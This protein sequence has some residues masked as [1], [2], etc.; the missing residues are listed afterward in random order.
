MTYRYASIETNTIT[1]EYPDI[2]SQV[3]RW[4]CIDTISIFQI[5]N[6]SSYLM[7][8]A[9]NLAKTL[10]AKILIG[11]HHMNSMGKITLLASLGKEES[12]IPT[13]NFPILCINLFTDP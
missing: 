13:L 2:K 4:L 1:H 12:Q 8:G 9:K 7:C 10:I 11:M 6:T 3:R 5:T